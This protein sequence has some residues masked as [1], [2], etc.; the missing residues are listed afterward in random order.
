[1]PAMLGPNFMGGQVHEP[2][3][4]VSNDWRR[5][6]QE[7]AGIDAKMPPLPD[8]AA[9]DK[10]ET[11]YL[12]MEYGSVDDYAGRT[13]PPDTAALRG[14]VKYWIQ[15]Q[16]G[17]F[18][19]FFTHCEGTGSAAMAWRQFYTFGARYSL[20]EMGPGSSCQSQFAVACLRG[21]AKAA[22][23]P[24]GSSSPPGAPGT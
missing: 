15:R 21:A 3:C 4:N 13:C 2:V 23:K 22:G 8:L 6:T 20:G 10:W 11:D 9:R 18:G 12:G 17:R 14:E 1:M 5:L 19:G 7:R 24:W 16:G